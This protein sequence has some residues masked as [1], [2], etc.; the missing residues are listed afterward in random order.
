MYDRTKICNCHIELSSRCNAACPLCARNHS[1]GK[2]RSGVLQTELKLSDI[3]KIFSGHLISQLRQF[4]FCGNLGDPC[5]AT[6]IIEICDWILANAHPEVR[7]AINTNGG[8]RGP[9]FWKQLA[10]RFEKGFNRGGVVFSIDGLADTNHIYRRQ[11]VWSKLWENLSA[12]IEAGGYAIWDF[13]RFRHN[14]HQVEEIQKLCDRLGIELRVKRPLGLDKQSGELR[15]AR[16]FDRQGRYEYSIYPVGLEGPEH[17]PEWLDIRRGI[18]AEELMP[19]PPSR[20]ELARS[21]TC[22]IKCK[23]LK[24]WGQEFY[25]AADGGLYPCCYVGGGVSLTYD[26]S[27]WQLK[28]AIQ[29]GGENWNNVLHHSLEKVLFDHKIQEIFY[30][31]WSRPSALEGRLQY[32]VNHCGREN[33]IDLIYDRR[34]TGND[35]VEVFPTGV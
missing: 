9:H 29:S 30:Q 32:C 26:F 18:E 5:M 31:S 22:G 10:Q 33:K 7:I 17:E 27:T 4:T 11:V 8:M 16:V 24:T 34:Y 23:S 35:E 19:P 3:Q 1:G 12:Y 14:S 28:R 25:I 13:L 2:P 15:P 20:P 6:E 21:Q